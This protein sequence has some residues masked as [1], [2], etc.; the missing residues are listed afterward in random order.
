MMR[1]V[2]LG[3]YI[4]QCDERNSKGKY[5]EADVKG[6][7][8]SKQLIET[9]ANLEGVSLSSYKIVN[10]N[11]FTFV[12]DTSR[13]GDKISLAFNN[14]GKA[15]IVSSISC[16]F[17]IKDPLEL[18]P[19]YLYLWFCRPEFDRYARFNSWGSA[20]EAFSYEDMERVQ[21]P[22][23]GIDEQRKIV[24]VWKGLRDLKV[25]NEVIAEPLF[26]L[27]QSYLKQLKEEYEPTEI[28]PYI[29]E[30]NEKNTSKIYSEDNVRGI[31]IQKEFIA[32]KANLDGVSLSSYKVVE[33]NNFSFNPNTA[34]MG[35]KICVSLNTS[36]MPYLV[37]AI[38]P[39][40]KIIDTNKLLPE[41]LMLWYKRSE[42]DR[43]SRF[44]SWG[45]AR[46]V[47]NYSDMYRVQIPIPSPEKQRAIVN[48]YNCAKE[49]KD[50]AN[51]TDQ[52]IKD[53]CPALIRQVI[54]EAS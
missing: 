54:G 42:F 27:C 24:S 7:A 35:E 43:Y 4:E 31:S 23:L 20:R 14:L 21:I 3:D 46:E 45:S 44:N 53:I 9:K 26:E 15:C 8:T 17:R 34:R 18:L 5:G 51:K 39:V 13:R 11:E 49:A 33:Q 19:D 28:G 30:V 22:L 16:V 29:E 1:W 12:P 10:P 6:I 40:F 37:S 36:D 41:Y 2:S 38:Y 47:F 50:I 32:T 52:L 48:I 25:Q